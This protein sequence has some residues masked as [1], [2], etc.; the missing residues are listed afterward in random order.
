MKTYQDF[1]DFWIDDAAY[2]VG[3]GTRYL[4]L[5][6]EIDAD[7]G[8][9]A[10]EAFERSQ[11]AHG[12]WIREVNG[13]VQ[14]AANEWVFDLMDA[15]KNWAPHLQDALTGALLGYRSD[16]IQEFISREMAHANER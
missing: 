6:G 1:I 12:V 14:V 2:E 7:H 15:A 8:P 10:A 13:E 3:R 5:P 11:R 16:K 9:Q 4:A